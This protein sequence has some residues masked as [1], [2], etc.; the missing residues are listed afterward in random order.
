M[1]ILMRM[2][3]LLALS[4]MLLLS[5]PPPWNEEWSM[6][7]A[8]ER[9]SDFLACPKS[10]AIKVLQN[11]N[12]CGFVFGKILQWNGSTSYDLEEI[13]VSSDLQKKGVG[14]KLMGRLEEVLVEKGV[15]KI[16]LITQRDS[17]PSSFYSSLGFSAIQNLVIMGKNI[18]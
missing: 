14:K 12:M 15:S 7:D 9:L 16:H 2:I 10:I 18:D 5:V 11:E 8:F 17:V 4:Y 13:C 6:E 3:C 1:H